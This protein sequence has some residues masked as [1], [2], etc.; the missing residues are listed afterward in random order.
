MNDI[1]LHI[2]SD[3]ESALGIGGDSK[4]TL[5]IDCSSKTVLGIEGGSKKALS[6][7]GGKKKALSIDG[8]VYGDGLPDYEG[9]YEANAL[10]SEQVFGTERKSMTRDFTVHAINYTEAPNDYGVTVTIGG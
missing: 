2:R 5:S 7:D 3:S 9:S 6:I 4:K 10:F 8:H 1:A